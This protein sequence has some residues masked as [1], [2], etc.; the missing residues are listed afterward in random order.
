MTSPLCQA[1]AIHPEE[2]VIL[3]QDLLCAFVLGLTLA[4]SSRSYNNHHVAQDDRKPST[5]PKRGYLYSSKS[6][7]GGG[8]HRPDKSNTVFA[9]F[10][11]PMA[12]KNKHTQK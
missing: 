8:I 11:T 2:G 9:T 4:Q 3:A 5:L 6:D 12:K 1:P 7:D 10:S